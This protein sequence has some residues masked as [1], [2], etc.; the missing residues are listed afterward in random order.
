MTTTLAEGKTKL[1]LPTSDKRQV[2]VL[3]KDS[4]TA[5]N[6]LKRDVI[7]GKGRLANETTCSVFRLLQLSGLPT[8]YLGQ[9]APDSFRWGISRSS[10][11]PPPSS[12]LFLV[13]GWRGARKKHHN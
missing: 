1:I 9:E 7:E 2:V 8:H 13:L 3:S 10:L 5:G 4:I 6:G 11:L 12:L